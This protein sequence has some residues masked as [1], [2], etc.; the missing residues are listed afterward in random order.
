M[1]GSKDPPNIPLVNLARQHAS[2]E[3]DLRDAFERVLGASAFVLGE[4]VERFEHEFARACGTEHC[5]G[6]SS[7]TAALAIMLQAAGIG[8]GD[9]VIVPAHTFIA[10]AL[11]V[12][13]AG[14]LPVCVDVE[15][16]SGLIDPQATAAAINPRTAAIL[17]VH[18]YGQVCDMDELRG[19][20]D[21]NGLALLEDAAQAHRAMYNGEPAGSFG[22][23]GAFSFY[24]SK[25]L[26]GLGDGGA[27]CTSDADLARRARRLRDLGRSSDNDGD[28]IPSFLSY[29]ARLDGL[30]AAFL[31]VKL[32]RLPEWNRARR[33]VA[34]SYRER[35]QQLD[36]VELLEE[37]PKSPC[38]Y[39]LFPIRVLGRDSLAHALRDSGIQTGVHYPR[40]VPDQLPTSASQPTQCATPFAHDWTTRE[41]SLPMFPELKRCELDAVADRV[42]AWLD[43][44]REPRP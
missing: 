35:F 28:R 15:E 36:G 2:L 42:C 10:T 29:N 33:E 3:A 44:R 20:A 41:L 7:G 24:P 12:C 14:A 30:Q 1:S 9:E 13:H 5:V 18:L 21:R 22:L 32:P 31:A 38:I 37:R 6:V 34:S 8:T 43:S 11:A 26:G 23:A 17:P 4:E 19:L 39:H 27:I 16:G 40:T 25:N